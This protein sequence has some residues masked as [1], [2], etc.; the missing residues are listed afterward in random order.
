M[1]ILALD[2]STENLGIALKTE[3]GQMTFTLKMGLRHSVTLLPWID[4]LLKEAN[5]SPDNLNLI[6]CAIG[7]GS[8][9]GLRIGLSTAKG[10][11]MGSGASIIGIPTLDFMA[12]HFDFFDGYVIPV[13]NAKKQRFYSAVYTNGTRE[14]EYLDIPRETFNKYIKKSRK[15]LLTGPS[16]YTIYNFFKENYPSM[17]NFIFYSPPLLPS[18]LSLLE[19]G[20]KKYNINGGDKIDQLIPLYLRKSEAEIKK[21]GESKNVE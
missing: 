16:G 8:F 14:S 5:I 13:I 18:P 19:L 9:T 6:V 3:R 20:E 11:A 7:P 4:K 12:N 1:N 2:T 10:M 21:F 17:R 15:T